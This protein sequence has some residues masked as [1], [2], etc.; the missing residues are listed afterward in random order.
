MEYIDNRMIEGVH[1][2]DLVELE[3]LDHTLCAAVPCL[4]NKTTYNQ[5]KS[6][7]S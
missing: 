6:T 4:N 2:G 7:L 5:P 3:Q 1:T